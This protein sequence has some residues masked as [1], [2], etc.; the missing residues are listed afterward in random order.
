MDVVLH[1]HQFPI[2]QDLGDR[3]GAQWVEWEV[4]WGRI[5][6]G[7]LGRKPPQI[8]SILPVFFFF[9]FVQA[10]KVNFIV[11]ARSEES[12]TGPN[13]C[14]LDFLP[15]ERP[16]EMTFKGVVQW[17][18]EGAGG[19]R[20]EQGELGEC[21]VLGGRKAIGNWGWCSPKTIEFINSPGGK[22]KMKYDL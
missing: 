1:Q 22:S 2:S 20:G 6:W 19:S 10:Q 5:L 7:V 18:D 4:E 13:Q 9:F 3:R 16:P 21:G 8:A 12:P 11:F 17:W 14:F 15:P